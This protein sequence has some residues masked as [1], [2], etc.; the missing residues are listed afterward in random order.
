L[1]VDPAVDALVIVT[2]D[3]HLLDIG[4]A[5]NGRLIMTPRDFVRHVLR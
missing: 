5:W 1:A 3:H 4:P 2:S